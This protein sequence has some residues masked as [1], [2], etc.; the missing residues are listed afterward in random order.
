MAMVSNKFLA[1]LS[2][3]LGFHKHL[4]FSSQV[5]EFQNRDYATELQEAE[6]D[7]NGARDY[8]TTTKNPPKVP[9][10]PCTF[11]PSVPGLIGST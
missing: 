9:K 11:T 3:K 7:S 1:A 10:I 5:I 4:R 6:R 2:V 8:W